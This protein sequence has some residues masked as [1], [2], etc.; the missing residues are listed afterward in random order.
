[1]GWRWPHR[2]KS[3]SLP[4]SPLWEKTQPRTLA[5]PDRAP[6]S[7]QR[8]P[9]RGDLRARRPPSAPFSA[10]RPTI[11]SPRPRPPATVA[12]PTRALAASTHLRPSPAARPRLRRHS[13]PPAG[14]TGPSPAARSPASRPL[15]ARPRWLPFGVR[16][17]L[18][19]GRKLPRAR[20]LTAPPDSRASPSALRPT[21]GPLAVPLFAAIPEAK[22]PQ[23]LDPADRRLRRWPWPTGS[24]R[25]LPRCPRGIRPPTASSVAKF[26]GA[27]RGTHWLSPWT[28]LPPISAFFP[29]SVAFAAHR[30]AVRRLSSP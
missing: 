6:T 26:R 21:A 5:P 27:L 16:S 25:L 9:D 17:G 14:P 4:H 20:P 12:A 28:R 15:A 10:P 1:M 8:H 7:P 22:P 13:A 23:A 3:Q 19:R 29:L 30:S 11:S 18:P 2:T 24:P